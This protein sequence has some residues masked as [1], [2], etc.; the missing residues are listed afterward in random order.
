LDTLPVERIRAELDKLIAAD[1]LETIFYPFFSVLARCIAL[2]PQG[3][4]GFEQFEDPQLKLLTLVEHLSP[5]AIEAE[6]VRLKYPK[7]VAV[8]LAQL[9]RFR[10]ANADSPLAIKRVL[11]ELGPAGLSLVLTYQ[12]VRG[13]NG[14]D[15]ELAAATLAQ[16]PVVTLKQ[17][18]INGHDLMAVGLRGKA[19]QTA[20]AGLLEAVMTEKLPNTRETLLQEA[21]AFL[22][23]KA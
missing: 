8:E 1:S 19:I 11:Q 4:A 13:I 15:P 22:D 21:R 12:E 6:L 2:S 20:L 23:E 16:N 17:L 10:Q 3:L 7:R 5:M 9:A 14:I 18:A